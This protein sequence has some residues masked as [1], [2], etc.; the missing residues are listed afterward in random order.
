MINKITPVRVRRP[1]GIIL[2]ISKN[3]VNPV[4]HLTGSNSHRPACDAKH[5]SEDGRYYTAVLS[6]LPA[7]L[8]APPA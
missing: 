6:R 7:F 3:L 4:L 2:L 5:A 8:S 1:F